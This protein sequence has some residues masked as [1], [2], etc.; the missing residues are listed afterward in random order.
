MDRDH[1]VSE[2]LLKMI[3]IETALHRA[4]LM[5]IYYVSGNCDVFSI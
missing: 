1:Y 5:G 3:K 4:W 2:G